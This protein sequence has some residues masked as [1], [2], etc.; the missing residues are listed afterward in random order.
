MSRF[1]YLNLIVYG[2]FL[3][4]LLSLNVRRVPNDAKKMCP[5]FSL[6][7]SLPF[8]TH[9]SH[10]TLRNSTLTYGCE[11]PQNGCERKFYINTI[12]LLIGCCFIWLGMNDSVKFYCYVF[13]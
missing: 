3:L 13:V 5:L 1:V 10:P 6:S 7:L 11:S 12:L 4:G 8:F 9:S 2:R